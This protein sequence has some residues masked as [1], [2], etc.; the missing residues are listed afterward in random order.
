MNRTLLL[1]WLRR[2]AIIFVSA[3]LGLGLVERAQQGSA[4]SYASVVAWSALA[5]GVAASLA[6]YWAYK[7]SC[8]LPPRSSDGKS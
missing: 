5:A 1:F 8:A 3:G 7:R 6:T 4:A 2:F